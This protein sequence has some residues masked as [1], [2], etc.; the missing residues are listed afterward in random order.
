LAHNITKKLEVNDYSFAH[1][2]FMLLLHYLVKCRNH[3]LAIYNNDLIQGS[4]CISWENHWDLDL[5]KFF[6]PNLHDDHYHH[7]TIHPRAGLRW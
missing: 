2:T 1:L 7:C 3:N 6:Y 5:L 4:A